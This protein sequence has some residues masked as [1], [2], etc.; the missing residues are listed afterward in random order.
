VCRTTIDRQLAAEGASPSFH[1]IDLALRSEG[2][3]RPEEAVLEARELGYVAFEGELVWPT[4]IFLTVSGRSFANPKDRLLHRHFV[5]V[6]RSLVDRPDR[7]EL[8]SPTESRRVMVFANELEQLHAATQTEVR[9]LG[10]LLEVEGIGQ[11]EWFDD[12]RCPWG[13]GIDFKIRKY[14]NVGSTADFLELKKWKR[15]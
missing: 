13:I 6:I 12:P 2:I 9:M 10:H 11:V 1:A 8:L 15:L 3:E 5:P 7:E 14:A 4:R